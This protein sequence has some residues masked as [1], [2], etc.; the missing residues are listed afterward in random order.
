MLV[1]VFLVAGPVHAICVDIVI[2]QTDPYEVRQY[3]R[4]YFEAVCDDA[5]GNDV[6]EM[7]A[8]S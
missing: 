4:R 3:Q 1:L 8:F 2:P 6:T 5:R 7:A